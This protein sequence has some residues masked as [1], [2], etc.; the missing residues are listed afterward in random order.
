MLQPLKRPEDVWVVSNS[1]MESY[2]DCKRKWMLQYH[3]RWAL[4]TEEVDKTK[5]RDIGT[6]VHAALERYIE[7]GMN[8]EAAL[9][10]L[11]NLRFDAEAACADQ[12]EARFVGLKVYDTAEAMVSGYFDWEAETGIND[13]ITFTAVEHEVTA[14]TGVEGV[15]FR[16]KVDHEIEHD[17]LHFVGD[18]KTSQDIERPIKVSNLGIPQS[19]SYV[20]ASQKMFPDKLYAGAYWTIIRT[21]KRGK[22]SKPPYYA[23]HLV[24]ISDHDIAAHERHMDGQLQDM[25]RTKQ[26]LEAGADHNQVAYPRR[27]QDCLWKCPFERICLGVST[28]IDVQNLEDFGYYHYDPNA[29]YSETDTSIT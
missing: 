4:A 17:G 11:Q 21:T 28:H 27:S 29:R 3:L 16:G 22:T 23:R 1:E 15:W 19:L 8:Q 14:P 20:W 10:Y 25:L 13:G 26:A 6:V 9:V 12:H 18:F 2:H 24:R 7:T 5:F